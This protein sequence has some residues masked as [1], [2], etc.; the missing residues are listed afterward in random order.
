MKINVYT[1]EEVE[2]DFALFEWCLS[3]WRKKTG[4]ASADTS[5]MSI[6]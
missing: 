4:L 3:S 5:I 1:N 6:M 2:L